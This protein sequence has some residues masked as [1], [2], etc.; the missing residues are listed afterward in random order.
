M[1]DT[2]TQRRSLWDVLFVEPLDLVK[3]QPHQILLSTGSVAIMGQF[4]GSG[5]IVH[6]FVGYCIAVGVEWAYLRGLAS[7]SKAP[8]IWGVVLNWSAFAIVVLWGVLWVAQ[9]TH[10]T[11]ADADGWLGWLLAS[12]HIVP[13]AW[14]SLCSAMTHQAAA[15]QAVTNQRQA[16][17]ADA[18]RARELEDRRLAFEQVQAEENAELERQQRSKAAELERIKD[19]ARFKAEL[20]QAEM[21]VA[22]MASVPIGTGNLARCAK[23]N[24]DVAWGTPSEAGTIRRWGCTACRAKKTQEA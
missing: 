4:A 17:S 20:K 15:A 5:G 6:P 3:A 1:S 24:K 8:T 21:P 22:K 19:M 11:P 2:L 16:N 10:V 18:A 9:V 12:A 23:C 7:D 13:I 14:L